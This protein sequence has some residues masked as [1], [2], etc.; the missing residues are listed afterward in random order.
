[1][2]SRTDSTYLPVGGGVLDEAHAMRNSGML[3]ENNNFIAALQ[4]DLELFDYRSTFLLH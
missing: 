4:H 3:M 1:M 2:K